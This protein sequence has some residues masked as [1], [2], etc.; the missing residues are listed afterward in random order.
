MVRCSKS[1]GVAVTVLCFALSLDPAKASDVE[2]GD[3]ISAPGG[4]NLAIGYGIW[5]HADRMETSDG[6]RIDNGLEVATGIARYV[7]FIDIGGGIIIDPQIIVPFGQ[8]RSR[9]GGETAKSRFGLGDVT[10]LSTIWFVSKPGKKPTYFGISPFVT[11]PTGA[12]DRDRPLNYGENRWKGVLQAGLVQGIAPRVAIDLT[13]DVTVYG[14]NGEPGLGKRLTQD[15]SYQVQT[16]LRYT[17]PSGTAFSVGHSGTWGGRTHLD[18]IYTGNRT[19]NQQIRAVAQVQI[20][21]TQVEFSASRT[22]HVVD[23]YRND[24]ILKVRVLQAF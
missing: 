8:I 21:K 6:Q 20:K 18:G 19:E 14:T 15:N 12:Y 17:L 9:A 11:I 7:R 1:M 4:T 3:Y 10:I 2:P 24:A 22:V 5:S 23:G 13:G 16:Y